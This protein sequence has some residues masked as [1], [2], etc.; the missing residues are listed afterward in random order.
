MKTVCYIHGLFGSSADWD[1]YTKTPGSFAI[2]LSHYD[3]PHLDLDAL[4]TQIGADWDLRGISSLS[5][6]G[7]SMGGRIALMLLHRFPERIEKLIAIGATFSIEPQNLMQRLFFQLNWEMRFAC[8]PL[9]TFFY[10]WYAQPLFRGFNYKDHQKKRESIPIAFHAKCFNRLHVLH[11]PDF[12]ELLIP[13][14]DR[15]LLLCGEHDPSCLNHYKTL[16]SMGYAIKEIANA[17]HAVFLEQPQATLTEI[18]RF[19][20]GKC[21]SAPPI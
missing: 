18:T 19:I 16:G 10:H 17:G 15:I 14:Q 13:Y 12:K 9:S 20:Y 3:A 4:C 5:L 1:G 7:Y 8:W 6:V 2:D 11:Q 21:L